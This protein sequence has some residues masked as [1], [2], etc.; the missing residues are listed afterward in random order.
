MGRRRYRIYDVFAETALAGNPLAVV[1]DADGLDDATMQAIAREFNLSETVFLCRPGN[2]VH[3]AAVRIF[4]P[5]HELP[6][7]GHPTV[8]SA[9]AL[10]EDRAAQGDGG[11]TALLVLEEGVGAVRCAVTLTAGG[12]GFAEFDLPRLPAAVPFEAS[13]EAVA[14]ALGLDHHAIG[15]ENHAV[16]AWSAGV[17]YVCVPVADLEAAGRARIDARLWDAIAPREGA[18]TADPYVY[19]RETVNHDCAFHARMFAP[20]AG[21]A[22]DP[23]TGSAAAA[24]VGAVLRFD[25]PVDGAHRLWIE[26]GIEMGRPSRIR[27][28]ID[29]AGGK[30]AGGRIGGQAVRIA[31]GTLFV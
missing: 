28:E 4:T 1:D 2:P 6:F 11:E 29:V 15:F 21:I 9:V 10:A 23:A 26:Q 14:A 12:P 5:A 18:V 8:G 27:V 24:F 16:S 7:A 17:P 19:C 25:A 22:E 30:L 31:E 3:A 13:N 20:D